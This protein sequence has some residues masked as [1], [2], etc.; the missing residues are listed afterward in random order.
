MTPDVIV[1]VGVLGFASDDPRSESERY[2]EAVLALRAQGRALLAAQRAREAWEAHN[3]VPRAKDAPR[4]A[5]GPFTRG[6]GGLL[7]PILGGEAVRREVIR[8]VRRGIARGR[9]ALRIA[10]NRDG[11]ASYWTDFELDTDERFKNAL[12]MAVAPHVG[13]TEDAYD[14]RLSAF[15]RNVRSRVDPSDAP[16]PI[17]VESSPL[18]RGRTGPEISVVGEKVSGWE[19]HARRLS[20]KLKE[21]GATWEFPEPDAGSREWVWKN[22]AARLEAVRLAAVA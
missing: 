17:A 4:T 9:D 18:A 20:A 10:R 1:P 22:Y 7:E 19:K 8:V 16:R 6:V 21:E 13:E 11:R 5:D 2:D 3:H 15:F 12:S 14:E